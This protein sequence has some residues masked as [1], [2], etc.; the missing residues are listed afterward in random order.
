MI[1]VVLNVNK[2]LLKVKYLNTLPAS[3]ESMR[4]A[5]RGLLP[6]TTLV[7]LMCA[8]PCSDLIT[9]EDDSDVESMYRLAALAE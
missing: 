3:I 1:K 5:V 4:E 2:R 6:E 7:S 8:D 9:M